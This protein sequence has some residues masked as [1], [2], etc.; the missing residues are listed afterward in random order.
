MKNAMKLYR[1]IYQFNSI[2][3]DF[4]LRA[5][6]EEEAVEKFV[7]IKGEKEIYHVIEC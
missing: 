7:Q 4:Y 3:T 1:I 2:V 6:S 5:N